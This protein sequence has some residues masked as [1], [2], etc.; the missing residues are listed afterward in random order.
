MKILVLCALV[1]L[2]ALSPLSALACACCAEPGTYMTYTDKAEPFQ[3]ELLK[4]MKFHS[5]AELFLTEADFEIVKGLNSIRSEVADYIPTDVSSFFK[6]DG[7]FSDRRWK[8]NFTTPSGAKGTLTLPLPARMTKFAVDI[9]DSDKENPNI[10]LY[11]EF[12][13]NGIVQSGTGFFS[14]GMRKPVRYQLVLQG[15]GNGCDNAEDFTHWLLDIDGPRAEYRLMGE[16]VVP[17]G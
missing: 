9:H 8:F 3:I 12:R 11:K 16:L 13:F 1:L 17:E 6:L 15:R 2:I 7:G 10:V 5:G 4:E 14:A